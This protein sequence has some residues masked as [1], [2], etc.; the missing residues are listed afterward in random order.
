[1]N[2]PLLYTS[3]SIGIGRRSWLM[4]IGAG[5]LLAHLLLLTSLPLAWRGAA[6]LLLLGLPG[7]LLVL[8][9]FDDERDLLVRCFLGLCGA[10][11]GQALLLLALH[12]LIGPLSWWLVLVYFDLVSLA[13]GWLL[14]WRAPMDP[15]LSRCR[16]GGSLFRWRWC[17]CW[18]ASFAFCFWAAPSSGR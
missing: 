10:I 13:L 15:T 3:A 9:L 5:A 7:F 2:W 8:A 14:F 1:M 17:C 16:A 18:P 4:M 12:A 11:M 6:T